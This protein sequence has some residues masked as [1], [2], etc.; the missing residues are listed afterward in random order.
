MA[1]DAA[2]DE[3]AAGATEGEMAAEGEVAA[4]AA[5]AAEDETAA[6]AA[7]TAGGGW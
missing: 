1:A 5:D 7:D 4:G 2:E 3:L 6:K